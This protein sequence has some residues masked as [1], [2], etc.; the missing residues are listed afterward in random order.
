METYNE[1]W[2]RVDRIRRQINRET[3]IIFFVVITTI[4]AGFTIC[5]MIPTH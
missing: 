1:H 3:A 4:A 2:E 5:L